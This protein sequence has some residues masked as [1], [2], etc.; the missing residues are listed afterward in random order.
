M[1]IVF[2]AGPELW[3]EREYLLWL[4]VTWG[5]VT[6]C[7]LSERVAELFYMQVPYSYISNVG[8]AALL[9]SL[10]LFQR[11]MAE[12]HEDEDTV[13]EEEYKVWLI[14]L[15]QKIFVYLV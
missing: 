14:D 4:K 9:T 8:S 12:A 5:K 11:I 2:Y 13:I 7:G 6:L 15:Q 3:E 10:L 1:T